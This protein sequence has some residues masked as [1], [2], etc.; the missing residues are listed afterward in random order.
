MSSK[1]SPFIIN[2]AKFIT[3]LFNPLFS[4]LLYFIYI[5]AKFETFSGGL[6]KFFLLVIVLIFPI[7]L[8]IFKRVKSGKYTD[9]DVS[10]REERKTLYYFIIAAL[11]VYI[12]IN[13]FIYNSLD[14]VMLYLLLL[15]FVMQ[16]SNLFIKS[17]MHTALNIFTAAL[18][19]SQNHVFGI[20][21][22]LVSI[23]VGFTRIIL[24]KHSLQEVLS[25][26]AIAL[27]VSLLFLNLNLN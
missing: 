8:W 24:K 15:L 18:F 11:S 26:T 10:N 21:W 1:V 9:A 17:S 7:F 14:P 16:I 20:I 27:V 23:I 13:Y 2:L 4:L 22:L 5:Q 25:G 3:N 19:F 12:I 6:K